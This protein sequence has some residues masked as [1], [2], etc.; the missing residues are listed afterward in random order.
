MI[1]MALTAVE[2]IATTQLA[3]SDDPVSDLVTVAAII[4]IAV[5]LIINLI[6]E[7]VG[8]RSRVQCVRPVRVPVDFRAGRSAGERLP[9]V[10]ALATTPEDRPG[11]GRGRTGRT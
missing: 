11:R 3:P 2:S 6:K 4:G 9:V 8:S 7:S 5:I 10:T 1:A